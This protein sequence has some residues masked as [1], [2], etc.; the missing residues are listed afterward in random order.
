MMTEGFEAWSKMGGAQALAE[1]GVVDPVALD[2]YVGRLF[3]QGKAE[4]SGADTSMIFKMWHVL[5]VEAW[6]R[7]RVAGLYDGGSQASRSGG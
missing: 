7:P 1:L 6:L 4:P 5:T 3:E 2:R